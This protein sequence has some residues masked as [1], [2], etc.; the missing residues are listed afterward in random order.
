[1]KK[2]I[3]DIQVGDLVLG[4]DGNWHKVIEKT[5]VK[6]SYNMYEIEFTNGFV[7]CSDTHLWN[8][9]I[10]DKMYTI[11]AEGIYQEF[12]WYKNRHVGTID[13]PTIVNIKKCEP[14]LV[15]CITTDAPDHQFAIY[16][17]NKLLGA[18]KQ[19]MDKL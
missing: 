14:E 8:I 6:V 13:G 19:I 11:D 17:D 1:M 2:K 3:K 18:T 10:E 7:K 4:T 15:Q 5:N 16:C 12:D 9:F